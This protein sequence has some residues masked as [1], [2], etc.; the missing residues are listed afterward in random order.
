MKK[1]AILSPSAPPNTNDSIGVMHHMLY[2]LYKKKGYDVILY[3]FFDFRKL[4]TDPP[5][6]RRLGSPSKLRSLI[7]RIIWLYFRIL[8]PNTTTH[9]LSNIAVGILGSLRIN[10]HLKKFK[11]DVLIIPDRCAPGAFLDKPDN[12]KVYLIEHHNPARF[13]STLMWESP[14]SIRDINIAI[15]LCQKALAIV[16]EVICPSQ[17][18]LDEFK[19]TYNFTGVI[20]CVP[21]LANIDVLTKS[22][23]MLK[24][25]AHELG[26]SEN[27]P[28][29]YIPS[30]GLGMKGERYILSLI[31][32]IRS[33][34]PNVVFYISGHQSHVLRKELE[35]ALQIKYV[36]MPGNQPYETNLAYAKSCALCLSPTMAESYGM[37]IFEA[38]YLGL[39][40]ITFNVDALSETVCVA[41]HNGLIPLLDIPKMATEV[42]KILQDPSTLL[43]AQEAAADFA[44]RIAERSKEG[45]LEL[46]GQ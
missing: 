14:A 23:S 46:T 5:D 9:Q 37:A 42:V 2:E 39:P 28:V 16:D 13:N 10:R 12:C 20:K 18:M 27:M 41:E 34:F 21:N 7:D 11:P 38:Q 4:S 30:G 26:F 35:L 29:I 33:L 22:K 15:K 32:M 3:T 6:I 19:K 1:I 44:H 40:V 17:Y 8:E 36:F 43:K 24:S 45:Y 25:V 31:L